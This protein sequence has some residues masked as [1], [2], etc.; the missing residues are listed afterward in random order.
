[1]A[2]ENPQ[3]QSDRN[4]FDKAR[5]RTLMVEEI[6]QAEVNYHALLLASASRTATV[7]TDGQHNLRARGVIVSINVSVAGTGSITTAIE[8]FEPSTGT[9]VAMLTSAA[10][11][12]AV[13]TELTIYPG[14]TPAANVTASAVLPRLWRVSVTHGN[15]NAISYSVGVST[16][17]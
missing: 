5:Q 17:T 6:L 13:R 14:F 15:A 10:I 1:M 11:T 16:L 12:T 2:E 4:A 7:Y 3:V 9:W 8:R